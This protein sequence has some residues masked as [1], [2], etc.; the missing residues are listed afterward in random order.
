MT[1]VIHDAD[2]VAVLIGSAVVFNFI[3]IDPGVAFFRRMGLAGRQV[4]HAIRH[5]D[6][7]FHGQVFFPR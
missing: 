4:D 1:P 6:S 7:P 5:M 3:G 2:D